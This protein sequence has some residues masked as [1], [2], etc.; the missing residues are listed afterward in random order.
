MVGRHGCWRIRVGDY[1]VVYLVTDTPS[2]VLVIE[3]GHR[4]DV[5]R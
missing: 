1:R 3:I 5:Y 2:V 4:R